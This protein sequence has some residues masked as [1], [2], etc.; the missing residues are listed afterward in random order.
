MPRSRP[1]GA[2]QAESHTNKDEA[3]APFHLSSFV[4]SERRG[5]I[6]ALGNHVPQSSPPEYFQIGSYGASSGLLRH[7][8][9][10]SKRETYFDRLAFP[11]WR[12]STGSGNAG[13][14]WDRRQSSKIRS[15]RS[16]IFAP[17]LTLRR[18]LTSA[19]I[20]CF[21]RGRGGVRPSGRPMC[22]SSVMTRGTRWPSGLL[23]QRQL[24]GSRRRRS[25]LRSFTF[26]LFKRLQSR[27]HQQKRAAHCS[28]WPRRGRA[29]LSRIRSTQRLRASE[30]RLRRCQDKQSHRTGHRWGF[31]FPR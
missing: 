6:S 24:L 27:K 30:P 28:A 4:L 14:S 9:L 23:R 17:T 31:P 25:P 29:L 8:T 21:H 26:C 19:F 5:N 7:F 13:L 3:G 15:R 16:S 18:S 22:T 2:H 20:R 1:G 10:S 11:K 12:D